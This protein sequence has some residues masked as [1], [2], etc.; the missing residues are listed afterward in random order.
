MTVDQVINVLV[1]VT[2]VEMMATIGLGV[3]FADVRGVAR[4]WR[5]VGRAALAN[6]VC[7]PAAVV[8]LLL[9]LGSAPL[10]AAG[11]LIVA[12][13]PG[14]PYG[15]PF[16]AL[17]RGDV[18]RSVGLMVILAGSSALVAPALLLILL[19]LMAGDQPLRVDAAKIVTT[20]L[21]TQLLP[22]GAGLLVRHWW[23]GV[24]D[25]LKRPATLVGTVLNLV[26]FGLILAV[27]YPTLLAIRLS[28]FVGMF[29]LLAL[30][31]AA[32][33]LLGGPG[34]E[35]RRAMAFTTGVRNVAVG[36]VIATASF[37]GTEAVTAALAYA[38]V[39]TIA[40]ALVALA[41]GRLAW[42]AGRAAAGRSLTCPAREGI[43]S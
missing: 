6:Y 2:L 1:M 14:A 38:L 28:G 9:L 7:V 10:V 30:T 3:T 40:L 13:C 8:G 4:D 32:G 11:F 41:W 23:P 37:P 36:L 18:P 42:G 34:G 16:T 5:L 35:G 27:Q 43:A 21:V 29:V 12:V 33:W 15:P 19:P 25:R 39:Q 26:T 20:L 24:A 22:L 31:V 17:A